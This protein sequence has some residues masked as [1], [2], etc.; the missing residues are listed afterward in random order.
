MKL[1]FASQNENKKREIEQLLD[2]R[3]QLLTLKDMNFEDELPEPYE[4][5]EGNAKSKARFVFE[6]FKMTCFS[7]DSGLEVEA[8]DGEPGVHS[9]RY[10]GEHKNSGDNIELVLKKMKGVVNRDAQFRTVICVIV[11]ETFQF[12]EGTV[13]GKIASEALGQSGFGYDPIFIPEGFDQTFAELSVDV[14]NRISH[15]AKAVNKMN[16][17]LVEYLPSDDTYVNKR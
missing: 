11:N 5:L 4:T 2:V 1:L 15:R 8:L 14:K 16:K 12:F 7:E 13:K 6:K 10:A 9:A 17:F 3:I